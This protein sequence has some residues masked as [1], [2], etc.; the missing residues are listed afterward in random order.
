MQNVDEEVNFD[1]S[2]SIVIIGFGQM[3]QVLAN[4]LSTPLVS[5]VDSD[6]VGWPY[7]GFDLN[8]AVVKVLNR[9]FIRNWLGLFFLNMF[10]GFCGR[11]QGNKVSRYCM[12]M[13]L[14]H[15]FCSL[16]VFHLLKQS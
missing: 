2:E 14:G 6:L 12:E 4:F 7:I 9:D 1:V 8:P 5:G 15:R 16:Q 11:N 13:D 3:G 10:V